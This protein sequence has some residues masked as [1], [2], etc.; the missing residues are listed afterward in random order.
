MTPGRKPLPNEVKAKRGTLQ[1]SRAKVIQLQGGLPRLDP[2]DVPADLGPIGQEAWNRITEYASAWLAVTDREAVTMACKAIEA[3][4]DLSARLQADGYVLFTDK[5]Y[6]YAHPAY[7]MRQS[8]EG[9]L[10]KWLSMLGLSPTDRAQL[11]IAMVQGQSLVDQYRD[12]AAKLKGGHQ[13]G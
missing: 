11:G 6:A 2:A 13:N 1:P 8:V 9:Q 7:G 5:G 12:R 3:H 4:V 10:Y